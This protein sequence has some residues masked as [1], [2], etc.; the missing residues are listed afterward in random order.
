MHRPTYTLVVYGDEK[1]KNIAKE[2]RDLVDL[3]N[4]KLRVQEDSITPT[5]NCTT[6][7][8]DGLKQSGFKGIHDF[9]K[10]KLTDVQL[11]AYL[12]PLYHL[13]DHDG[14]P[15][16]LGVLSY[17]MATDPERYIPRNAFQA[18]V[19]ALSHSR[20]RKKHGIKRIDI[21]QINQYPSSRPVGG[22]PYLGVKKGIEAVKFIA[23]GRAYD[24]EIAA[25]LNSLGEVQ[26]N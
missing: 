14:G 23:D 8:M 24:E 22:Y 11:L 5:F 26:L 25:W 2:T 1:I 21:V 13:F 3:E 6:I 4:P 19:V 12:N 18:Y 10:K 15:L 20:F 7:A 16:K 17:A 9:W